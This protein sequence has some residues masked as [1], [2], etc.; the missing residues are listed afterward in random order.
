M[1]TEEHEDIIHHGAYTCKPF[2]P[3]LMSQSSIGRVSITGGEF[4]QVSQKA[5]YFRI[6]GLQ[7]NDANTQTFPEYSATLRSFLPVIICYDEER[8]KTEVQTTR[9]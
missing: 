9:G 1:P 6:V 7:K 5:L 3:R 2:E 8:H 4:M